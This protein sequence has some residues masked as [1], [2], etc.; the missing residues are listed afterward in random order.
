M[1]ITKE[2]DMRLVPRSQKI[3]QGRLEKGIIRM[4]VKRLL[5]WHLE[6]REW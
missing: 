1:K 6:S 3:Y 5:G 2:K 4:I